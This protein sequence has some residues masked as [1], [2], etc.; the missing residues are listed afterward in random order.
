MPEQFYTKI[1]GVSQTN[2]DGQDR[3][4]IIES[5]VSVGDDLTLKR[6]PDNP[7]DPHAIAVFTYDDQIGYLKKDVAAELAP[8]LD[9]YQLINCTVR[10]V[11][12]G[13]DGKAFGVNVSMEV[14]SKAESQAVFDKLGMKKISPRPVSK[15][16]LERKSKK[17]FW[18][19]LFLC[20][21]MGYLGVHRFY[22]GR[23]NWFFTLTVGFLLFG[24]FFDFIQI[25]L[26]KFKDRQGL[27]ITTPYQKY[28][29]KLFG[30]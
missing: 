23:G 1:V 26:G 8:K 21:F 2:E 24:W 11:T 20:V 18:L 3:Q 30:K 9:S 29:D 19:T 10:E 17:N 4:E 27:V 7:Y 28:L 15:P 14:Y 13:E 12:G 16:R 25:L 22:A 6:E 5:S